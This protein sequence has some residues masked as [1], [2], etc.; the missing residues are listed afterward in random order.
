MEA[1][2]LGNDSDNYSDEDFYDEED[3][4]NE[5]KGMVR[6]GAQED[7]DREDDD[8]AFDGT[9]KK[10]E[11]NE[12]VNIYEK[13]LNDDDSSGN[14][15]DYKPTESFRNEQAKVQQAYGDDE[16]ELYKTLN[17]KHSQAQIKPMKERHQESK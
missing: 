16:T 11:L 5:A 3:E 17:P 13:Y 14:F 9:V 10:G 8:F 6:A 4:E 15:D 7:S 2:G 1:M 12:V